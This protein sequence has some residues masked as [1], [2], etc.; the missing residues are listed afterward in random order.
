MFNIFM[1]SWKYLHR[2]T[3]T[4][5]SIYGLVQKYR[6]FHNFKKRFLEVINGVLLFSNTHGVKDLRYPLSPKCQK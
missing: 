1:I 5:E 2:Y 3:F 4:D 6:R